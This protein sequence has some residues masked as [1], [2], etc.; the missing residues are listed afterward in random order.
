MTVFLGSVVVM[1]FLLTCWGLYLAHQRTKMQ[2]EDMHYKRKNR[3]G[4]GKHSKDEPKVASGQDSQS[5]P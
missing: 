4:K 3:S 5:H 2:R 1:N